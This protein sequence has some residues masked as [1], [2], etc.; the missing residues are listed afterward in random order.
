MNATS[1]GV[2]ISAAK[3]RSPSFSRSSSSTTTTGR[4][5]SMSAMAVS[6]ESRRASGLRHASAPQQPLDVLG[7]HV[8]LEVDRV[9]RARA[10]SVVARSVLGIRLTSNQGSG[11]SAALTALTVSETPSTA[12]EPFSTT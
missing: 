6:I 2:A 4:P 10:P 12:I 5:A 3:I 8:D 9:P 11:S 7:E 1:S